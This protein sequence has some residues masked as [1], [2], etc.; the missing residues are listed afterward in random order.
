[1]QR[2]NP[3]Q[4]VQF[5]PRNALDDMLRQRVDFLTAY[6]N[7]AYAQRYAA[8]VQQVRQVDEATGHKPLALTE[9][10]ARYLFKLMA[11]KDEYEVARLHTDPTFHA[12]ISAM[13]E[14]D[15]TLHYHLAPPLLA[16]KNDKGE[17]QKR[18][19]G[20]VML[21]AFRLLK[22]LKFL[23]G[24]VF[25]VF[26]KTEERRQER[27][28]IADYRATMDLVLAALAAD[29]NPARYQLALQLARIPEQIKGFGH[30]KARNLKTAQHNQ[31]L[32]L[33][34][35]RDPQAAAKAA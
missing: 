8:Y 5:T 9:A 6:Q 26:G 30:V 19:F 18:Q 29:S 35:W 31:R 14:G 25:D 7:A 32:L 22:Q 13:F 16:Q 1:V 24:T 23:R 17:L 3:G 20:P 28:S 21:T 2:L 27:A 34:Q 4:V 33:A 12:K 11:Y 15:Y 10:V